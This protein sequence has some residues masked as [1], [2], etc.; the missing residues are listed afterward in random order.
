MV[1]P[2]LRSGICLGIGS[3]PAEQLTEE[4][5]QAWQPVLA[6]WYQHEPDKGVHSA[7]GWALRH[8]QRQLP[9]IAASKQPAERT[10]LARQQRRHD[11]AQNP[12]REFHPQGRRGNG[13]AATQ[14][15]NIVQKVTLTR[16]FLLCDREVSVGLFQQFVDDPDY[17][18]K[19]KARDWPGAD[20]VM[21]PTADHPVQRVDWNHAVLFCNWLSRKEGRKPCYERTGQIF[22]FPTGTAVHMRSGG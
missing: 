9:T 19:E 11:D 21:S 8:W 13:L 4:T 17:P 22:N 15:E 6:D 10:R 5:K 14:I 16:P 18:G 1:D 3:T 12:C 7:A 2:A 20:S